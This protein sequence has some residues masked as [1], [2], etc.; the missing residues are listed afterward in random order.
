MNDFLLG[1]FLGI[2]LLIIHELSHVLVSKYLGYYNG[3]TM[4]WLCP[5]TKIKA[6]IPTK[7]YVIIQIAG[8]F[9]S[10]LAL[11]IVLPM[12][13]NIFLMCA[14]LFFVIGFSTADFWMIFK[15]RK[16]F[17]TDELLERRP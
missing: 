12:D 2:G 5:A 16:G 11:I 17:K 9:G 4:F 8:F 15:V 14:G 10:L 7:S 6:P 1:L 13:T 3:L